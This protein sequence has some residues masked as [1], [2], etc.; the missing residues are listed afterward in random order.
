MTFQTSVHTP[1]IDALIVA[2][3]SIVLAVII[4]AIVSAFVVQTQLQR[5]QIP[6]EQLPIADMNVW[7]ALGK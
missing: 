4:T 1:S 5:Y 7:G 3:V 2:K 6:P